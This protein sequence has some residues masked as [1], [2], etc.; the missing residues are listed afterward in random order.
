MTISTLLS[1]E[2]TNWSPITVALS[3]NFQVRRRVV[4]RSLN[5]PLLKPFLSINTLKTAMR[6]KIK[7]LL[8]SITLRCGKLAIL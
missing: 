4:K 2:R 8:C 7:R 6:K 3:I 1:M 5:T